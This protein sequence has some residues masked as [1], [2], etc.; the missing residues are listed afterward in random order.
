MRTTTTLGIGAALAALVFTGCATS[1]EGGGKRR[2]GKRR[3][4][5]EQPFPTQARLEK[6]GRTPVQSPLARVGTLA[7]VTEWTLDPA[8][9]NADWRQ[10]Y[11]G[12]E[13]NAKAYAAWVGQHAPK[14][15][16]SAAMACAAHQIARFVAE[17]GQAI[18]GED[19]KAFTAARCGIPFL[20]IR[21]ATWTQPAAEFADLQITRPPKPMLETIAGLPDGSVTGMGVAKNEDTVVLVAA[22]T[23]PA[24]QLQPLPFQ[25]GQSGEVVVR[26]RYDQPTEWIQAA[27]TYGPLGVKSCDRVAP[28]GA[29]G[30]FAFRCR[31][32]PDDD[33][34][35]IEI[36][37]AAKGSVLGYPLSR[38]YISP[39]GSAPGDY[40][41]PTLNLPIT[42]GDFSPAAVVA[43]INTLRSQAELP[44]LRTAPQQ[45]EVSGNLFP[46]LIANTDV[47]VRNEAAM[48]LLA[49]WRVDAVLRDAN[50]RMTFAHGDLSL[51][52]VLAADLLFPSFRSVTLSSDATVLSTAVLD[53]AEQGVRGL[54]HVTY[55]EFHPQD[56]ASEEIAFLDALDA[57]RAQVDLPPITRVMGGEDEVALS[58]S[59]ERI[60]R[61]EATPQEELDRMLAYFR[62]RVNRT[63]YGVI[64]SPMRI[65]GWTPEFSDELFKH[66]KIAAATSI[67]YFQPEGGA[68]GQHVVLLVFTPL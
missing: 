45:N 63:F 12:D 29:G 10:G 3:T 44:D 54:L 56:F 61:G 47:G 6:L 20:G 19:I 22:H 15:Q 38:S 66:Q 23:V 68:W 7:A 55:E 34:A 14:V 52:R 26:G 4:R 32:K 58:D 53:D 42:E 43:G 11:A 51:S 18:A 41:A 40:K 28:S 49:G 67:S 25:S 31:T 60:R 46:H 37:A 62:D 64:Y 13:P 5:V 57:A 1:P 39:S 2:A 33:R 59:A 9:T 35:I 36:S 27:V 50:F 24:L 16:E 17:H 48:G 21:T 30:G 8:E 65:D